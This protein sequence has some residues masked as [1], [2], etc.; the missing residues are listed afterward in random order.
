M[1]IIPCSLPCHSDKNSQSHSSHF[2]SDHSTSFSSQPSLASVPSLASKSSQIQEQLSLTHYQ[3][4][5]TLKGHSSYVSSLTLSGKYLYSGSSNQEIRV[6][7]HEP[8]NSDPIH[9]DDNV[10]A[11]RNGAVKSLVILGN[12]LFSAHQ[13]NKIRVWQ[14]DDDMNQKYKKLATLP[15]LG[16][17]VMKLLPPKNYVQVRRHKKCTW[18]HHVDAVSALV[19]SRDDALLYSASWDRTFKIWRT[20][21]F[22]CLE[23]VN[24][25]HDDAINAIAVSNNGFV[26]T[27]SADNKIKVWN[28]AYG[29]KKHSLVDTLEK[30][31]SGVN[32]LAL[33]SD[34]SILYSGACDRSIVVWE[35][36]GS[37][38]RDGDD[39]GSEAHMVVVGA[40]RGHTKAVLCLA[41]VSDLVCSG[42]ADKTVRIWRRGVG[43]CYSCLAVLEGHNGPVKCL[44]AKDDYNSTSSTSTASYLVYSG[45][46]D[47][48][49]KIWQISLPPLI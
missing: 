36:D 23:S 15:T 37:S 30:H 45:S 35:K 19:F 6:W 13:D 43:R 9:H 47:C 40:L 46:L 21:D 29:D 25:A 32:A 42:S 10:V 4:I 34:G 2:Y 11:I 48:D 49:I 16:D 38:G 14:I 26:Y 33:S 41:I 7:N 5:S 1:G 3:C 31:R 17:R 28:K 20:S 8:L 24:N 18:V 27:G 44:T 12:T 39:C 22:R